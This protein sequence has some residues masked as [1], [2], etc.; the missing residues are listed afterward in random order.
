VLN[1][2]NKIKKREEGESEIGRERVN[3]MWN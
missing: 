2:N 3:K 1:K